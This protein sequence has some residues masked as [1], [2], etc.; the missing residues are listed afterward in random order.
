MNK[1]ISENFK[2]VVKKARLT[3]NQLISTDYGDRN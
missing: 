3:R 1:N 2:N